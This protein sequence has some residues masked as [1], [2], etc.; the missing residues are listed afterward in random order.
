[1]WE[2]YLIMIGEDPNTTEKT[3][4]AWHFEL[5]E[6]AANEL[7]ELVVR[8]EKRATA[9]S[10]WIF[11]FDGESLPQEGDHSI[12]TDWNGVAVCILQTKH[13]EVVR[14]CDV[15]EEFAQKEGEGD[16][17]LA[18]WRRDHERFFRS[19]CARM[20]KAFSEEMPVLCEEFIVVYPKQ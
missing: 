12:V 17:S 3:Y 14:F 9:S 8:G 15:T 16:R 5:T 4:S 2:S 11:E 20:G 13:L 19:E 10:P 6:H 7:A 18:S 1:M